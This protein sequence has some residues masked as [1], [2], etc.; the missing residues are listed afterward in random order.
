M[1]EIDFSV[2]T[3]DGLPK[4]QVSVEQDYDENI[5]VSCSTNETLLVRKTNIPVGGT[6]VEGSKGKRVKERGGKKRKEKKGKL[7]YYFQTIR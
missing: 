6:F 5:A 4:I 3:A 1:L 2:P 7:I